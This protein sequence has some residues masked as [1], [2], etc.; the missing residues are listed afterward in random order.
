MPAYRLQTVLG[1][2]ERAEEAAKQVF[3]QAVTA[4]AK[5]KQELK[6]L[7]DDLARRK[8]ERKAKVEAYFKEVMAGGIGPNSMTQMHRFEER[9]KDEEALVELDIEKQK[10]V[11]KKAEKVVEQRRRE[12]AEA[13]RDLKAIVKHKEKFLSDWRKEVDIRE[14]LAR[15]E[16]GN[17]L[18][19]ARQREQ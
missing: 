18:F 10:Q 7:E 19:L 16:I 6:R 2:R 11:I 8:S 1:M 12:L 15:E 4:L 3:A 9:L 5:A 13:A 14:D 17:A